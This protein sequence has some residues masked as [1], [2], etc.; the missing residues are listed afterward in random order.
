MRPGLVATV[1]GVASEAEAIEAF[2]EAASLL[3]QRGRG[4]GRDHAA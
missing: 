4:R 3:R 1:R 2:R